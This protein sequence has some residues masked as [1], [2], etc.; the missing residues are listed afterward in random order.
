[1]TLPIFSPAELAE[2]RAYAW[3]HYLWV[4]LGLATDVL[5]AALL[6]R[7]GVRPLH[8]ASEHLAGRLG[9]ALGP[10][11]KRPVLRA[12]SKV[13]QRL[14]GDET[15]GTALL[16]AALT[17]AL[18]R[19]VFLPVG[20]Y[21][22]FILEHRHGLSNSGVGLYLV[23]LVKNVG[24]AAVATGFLTLGLFGLMRRLRRWWLVLGVICGAALVVSSAIDPYRD[25]LFY[26]QAELPPG[27]LRTQLVEL[28][29]RADVDVKAIVVEKTSVDTKRLDAYFAGQGGTR[30]IV[31]TDSLIRSFSPDEVV[32]AVA[33][34][35]GH[36]HQ[37]RWPAWAASALALLGFL[38][39]LDR[40][41][42][43]AAARRWFGV[44]GPVDIRLAPL[45]GVSLMILTWVTLPVS[46]WASRERERDADR[47]ALKVTHDPDAFTRMLVKAARVNKMDPSPPAWVTWAMSHPSIQERL[48][49]VAAPK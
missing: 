48:D 33:H 35:A 15:W 17:F 7:F 27:A 1:M 38:Y 6:L 47:F 3:P 12:L 5:Y 16:F 43:F 9:H 26:E 13:F 39:L 4:P 14:W 8:R 44:S 24:L 22:G 32:A 10:L 23:H 49:Q 34:E 46:A 19:A 28:L 40:L 25:Q 30:T 20:V 29:A 42:R 45:M 31:L 41:F 18:V 21:F 2:V 11:F 37:R 36:V